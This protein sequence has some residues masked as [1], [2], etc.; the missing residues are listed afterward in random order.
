MYTNWFTTRV[1]PKLILT[2]RQADEGEEKI[3]SQII[4]MH[5]NYN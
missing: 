2:P 4:E 3:A 1:V 5:K